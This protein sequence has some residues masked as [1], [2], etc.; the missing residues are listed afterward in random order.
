MTGDLIACWALRTRPPGGV[1]P[2]KDPGTHLQR[3]EEFQTGSDS[4]GHQI[5]VTCFTEAHPKKAP[6]PAYIDHSL[7]SP[8][9]HCHIL[10]SG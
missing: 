1:C 4:S 7:C 3:A 5:Q 9:C 2:P 8:H 10:S 6:S